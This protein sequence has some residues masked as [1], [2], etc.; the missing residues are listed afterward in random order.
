VKPKV[1][2]LRVR[3]QRGRVVHAG[4]SHRL[5]VDGAGLTACAVPFEP[6]DEQLSPD[7]PVTCVG[8]TRRTAVKE[9]QR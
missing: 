7:A 3:L 1:F 8:C 4:C 5:Y 6:G 2:S 9:E